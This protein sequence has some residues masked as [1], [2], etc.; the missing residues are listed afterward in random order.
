M[1]TIDLTDRY[2]N[3]THMRNG[4]ASWRLVRSEEPVRAI[5]YHHIAGWYGP[6]LGRNASRDEET[7]RLDALALDH[8]SRFGIGP[9]YHYAAFPSGR[10]YAIGKAGTHRAHT[11][12]RAPEGGTYWNRIAVGIVSFGNY[13]QETPTNGLLDALGEATLDVEGW[14]GSLSMRFAH[15]TTP[16]VDR[17]G[18]PYTQLTLC[19]GRNLVPMLR[20]TGLLPDGPRLDADYATDI[21]EA[22][23]EGHAE[24]WADGGVAVIDR[25]MPTLQS[26]D[27]ES[28]R[29]IAMARDLRA[30]PPPAP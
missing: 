2:F 20:S 28:G 23:R 16:T 24:G 17:S 1:T 6:A 10:N 22:R 5:I 12:G 7:T 26:I 18:S 14:A 9:G 15:G 27:V 8:F 13:E 25:L 3:A 4:P 21:E 11:K 19:P 29:A 30:T